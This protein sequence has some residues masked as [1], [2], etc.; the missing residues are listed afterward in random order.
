MH[1]SNRHAGVFI[2][3]L[4]TVVFLN[5]CSDSGPPMAPVSGVVTCEGAPV[6]HALVTFFPEGIPDA[7]M[8]FAQTDEQGRFDG[9]RSESPGDGAAV[10]THRVT[11]T[12][13]WGPG[14]EV[15]LTADGMQKSPPR[16]PWA[17]K[18][19]DSASSPLKVQVEADKKNHIELKLTK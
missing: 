4:I 19:R 7:R 10:G 18:F 16:G 15:P 5:G 13:S 17:G 12:E 3:G 1:P 2:T 14:V 8:A 9:L 6:V 11:V